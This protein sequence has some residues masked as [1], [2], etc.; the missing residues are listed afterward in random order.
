MLKRTYS[1]EQRVHHAVH[2]G[3][4]AAAAET[5]NDELDR[6]GGVE[7]RVTQKPRLATATRAQVEASPDAAGFLGQG[8]RLSRGAVLPA[9]KRER[10]RETW[11]KMRW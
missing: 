1:G 11:T 2:P 9:R 5:M 6:L 10:N 4:L 7:G 8:I 3:A